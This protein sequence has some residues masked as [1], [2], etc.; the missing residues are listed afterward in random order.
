MS[1]TV[2]ENYWYPPTSLGT[3]NPSFTITSVRVPGGSIT[4]YVREGIE[5]SNAMIKLLNLH[6]K[7]EPLPPIE[8]GIQ[9]SND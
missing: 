6:Y 1:K 8:G 4:I 3:L 2:K 9:R 5:L 7:P